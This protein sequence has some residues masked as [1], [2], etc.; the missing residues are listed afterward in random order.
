MNTIDTVVFDVGNVLLDWN[1]RHLYRKLIDDAAEMEAF[2]A[3]ICT[4]DWN[5][6]QDL[7]RTWHEATEILIRRHPE[8]ASLIRAFDDRWEETVAGPIEGS[9][10]LLRTLHGKGTP[11]YAITNFSAEKF[12]L[13]TARYDFFA[14]FEDIVVSGEE[15]TC[16]PAAEIF[17]IFLERSGRNAGQC[18]FIDDSELNIAGA[19]AVGLNTHHFRS[20][21]LLRQDLAERG[22]PVPG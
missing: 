13:M 20:P 2:L 9:V 1:P 21:E 6:Q 8:K 22:F 5:F 11:L 10:A 7:G 4:P 18:L 15:R 17:D 12:P 3:E 14:C 19:E 16:K